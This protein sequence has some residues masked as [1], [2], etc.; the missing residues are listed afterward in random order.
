MSDITNPVLL[1]TTGQE[2]KNKLNGALNTLQ[3]I[4]QYKRRKLENTVHYGI[5]IDKNDSNPATRMTYMYDCVGFTP[6]H[7]DF[8]NGKFD[9]GS[10]GDAFFVRNNYPAMVKFDGTED[11]RLSKDNQNYKEDGVTASDVANVNYAGNAM[12]VFNCKIWLYLHEDDN[13]E[14]IEVSNIKFNENFYDY[15]YVRADGTHADKLYYPMFAGYKDSAGKLRSIADAV[16]WYN[17][18]GTQNEINAA[19]ATGSNWQIMDYAH[20]IVLNSLLWLMGLNDNTQAVYGTGKADGYVDD[21]SQNY[22]MINTGTLKDK[23]QFFG[24]NDSDHEVKVFFIEKWWGNRLDRCLGLMSL[25]GVL[26]YKLTPPYNLTGDGYISVPNYTLPEEGWIQLTT[27]GY[28]G[29]IPKTVS[30]YSTTY[31]C[32][33]LRVNK[34][35]QYAVALFGSCVGNNSQCGALAMNVDN[36]ASRSYQVFGPSA[37]LIQP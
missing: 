10:W 1:D 7:M 5:R 3:D 8:T 13:Y 9:Y 6:A 11:Y 26:K 25:L 18:G 20:K 21:A 28:F 35:R 23:G 31:V 12:S 33:Y 36:E 14:Y 34:T 19:S 22:G 37:Y 4:A 15:G 27:T 24:Y 29:R 30:V 2:F 32:D 16:P 17:T